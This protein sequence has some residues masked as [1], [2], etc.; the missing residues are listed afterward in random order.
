[1]KLIG[2]GLGDDIDDGAAARP[3]LG[4]VLADLNTELLDR[5]HRWAEVP[6][7]EEGFLVIGAVELIVVFLVRHA[8]CCGRA[9]VD[10]SRSASAFPD[11]RGQRGQLHEV[12][13]VERQADHAF[14]VDHASDQVALSVD[15]RCVPGY[16]DCLGDVADLHFDIDARLLSDFEHNAADS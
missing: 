6:A 14:R 9:L 1:M 16:F 5:I 8:G 10:D 12:T 2:T 13:T 4:R 15:H 11:A 3:K 7:I